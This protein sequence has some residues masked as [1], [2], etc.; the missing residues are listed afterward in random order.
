MCDYVILTESSCDLPAGLAEELD[1]QVLPLSVT[2]EGQEYLNYL[3]GREIS[4]GEF[5]RSMRE[6]SVGKTAAANPEQLVSL[7]EPILQSGKD[8]LYLGF[9]S[10]LSST[11]SVA[12]IVAEEL[13]EKYPEQKVLVVD[14]LCASLG[15]G[16][17]VYLAAQQKLA[18]KTIEEVRDFA[19]ETRPYL[20]HWFTVDDLV[21]LKRGG[22]LSSASAMIGTLLNI[23]PVLHVD[24]AGRLV[25][26]EKVRGRKASLQRMLDHMKETAVEPEKQTVFISH[27]DCPEDAALM[28]ALV[29]THCGAAKIMVNP[30]GPVVGAHSG[31]GT[32]ALFFLGSKR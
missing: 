23:K 30:I 15:Q 12:S 7:M 29:R 24:D 19:V 6:G 5:Y 14:T 9:S 3:D 17:L 8:L 13:K 20:C 1:I 26:V 21:Y 18:G 25:G 11:Y 32:L 16:L 2:M 27:A 4:N 22:R 31:P 10:A 28:E